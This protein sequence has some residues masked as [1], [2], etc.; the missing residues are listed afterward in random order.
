MGP[1]SAPKPRRRW[2]ACRG[3]RGQ[4]KLVNSVHV[5]HRHS[6]GTRCSRSVKA[7]LAAGPGT[8]MRDQELLGVGTLNGCSPIIVLGAIVAEAGM[9]GVAIGG[10]RFGRCRRRSW[11]CMQVRVGAQGAAAGPPVRAGW[12]SARPAVPPK[13]MM[14]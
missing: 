1:F 12:A 11:P 2:P 5:L 4:V 14:L 9:W 7:A 3:A 10:T 8:A 13:V 6:P